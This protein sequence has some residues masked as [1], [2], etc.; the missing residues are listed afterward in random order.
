M[1]DNQIFGTDA[2]NNISGTAG[3][4]LIYGYAGNDTLS[5]GAGNDVLYGSTGND[6][7][8]GGEGNDQLSGGDGADYMAGGNGNDT[9]YVNNRQDVVVET[10]D[11]GT[12]TVV[13]MGYTGET[14]S[15]QGYT[16]R[17]NVEVLRL[18]MNKDSSLDL[19]LNGTGN[20]L[21]NSMVGNAGDNHL[22][23]LGGNDS[24]NGGAGNDT[25]HGGTG[26]D[27]LNGGTG[28]DLVSYK[29]ATSG[30]TVSLAITANQN[31]GGDGVDKLVG[32]ENL[33]GSDFNDRLTGDAGSNK[34]F[35]GAGND[36]I[37][38]GAGDDD[39]TGG[40]GNDIF[41]FEST[42]R[43][44]VDTIRG[45]ESGSDQL[46]FAIADGYAANAGFTN[47]STAVGSGA[48][49]VYDS[50]LHTLSYDADGAGGAAAVKLA[51]FA[52]VDLTATDIHLV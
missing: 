30:V 25:I 8:I 45:F 3:R 19:N 44:G 32:F 10:S 27:N 26:D 16:L 5:G 49:F 23:G 9:Y 43:N 41:R 40:T 39:L 17:E 51:N 42:A 14:G 22:F 21:G 28:I 15:N 12:D 35:A 38:G 13:F 24:I 18:F 48:Q 37:R 7:L 2:N 6:R 36:F 4:D 1:A 50:A 31:T 52:P 29:T 20:S 46:E 34:I 33:E 11:G 47:G